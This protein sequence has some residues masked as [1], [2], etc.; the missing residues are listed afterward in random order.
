MKLI[1]RTFAVLCF[2]GIA[3][4]Q[5]PDISRLAGDWVGAGRFRNVSFQNE[6]GSVPFALHIDPDFTLSGK[7][8]NAKIEPCKPKIDGSRIDYYATVQGDIRPEN[9]FRKN[10]LVLLI[11]QV[12]DT[13]LLQTFI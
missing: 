7:V 4:A 9:V 5:T 13:N 1:L 10:H 3:S 2:A 8:G 6:F 11:M 12:D